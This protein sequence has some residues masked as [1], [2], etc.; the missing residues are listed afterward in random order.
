MCVNEWLPEQLFFFYIHPFNKL[1]AESCEEA[2]KAHKVHAC[3]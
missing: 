1:E 3:A 2:K